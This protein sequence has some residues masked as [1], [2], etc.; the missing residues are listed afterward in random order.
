MDTLEIGQRRRVMA[1]FS[2]IV[3]IGAMFTILHIEGSDIGC[4]FD[5]DIRGHNLNTQFSEDRCPYG[6]GRWLNRRQVHAHT[7]RA[8]LKP[9]WEL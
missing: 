5:E 9:S 2:Y 7:E 1:D 6:H 3:P 4:A 8:D